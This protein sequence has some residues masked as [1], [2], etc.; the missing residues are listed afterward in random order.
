[1]QALKRASHLLKSENDTIRKFLQSKKIPI[2][3]V[4]AFVTISNNESEED[5]AE[6]PKKPP[7]KSNTNNND[8]DLVR[9]LLLVTKD[10]DADG[11]TTTATPVNRILDDTTLTFLETLR[12]NA[13]INVASQEQQEEQ[14]KYFEEQDRLYNTTSCI[15]VGGVGVGSTVYNVNN[16]TMNATKQDQQGADIFD[17]QPFFFGAVG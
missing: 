7:S 13:I 12:M 11:K 8:D 4:A 1:M 5:E 15:G 2:D 16:A 17:D 10:D 3:D 14:R 6:T 9:S